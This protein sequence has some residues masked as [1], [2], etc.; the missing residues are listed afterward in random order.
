VNFRL[1]RAITLAVL[2]A[3]LCL[4]MIGCAANSES[5]AAGQAG[6]TQGGATQTQ[7]ESAPSP[8]PAP[9]DTT[10]PR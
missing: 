10:T 4:G 7:A 9:A 8:A 3:A 2:V 6:S 5:P 1:E